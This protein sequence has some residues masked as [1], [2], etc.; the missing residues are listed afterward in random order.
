[1]RNLTP[2]LG[3][4]SLLLLVAPT[5]LVGCPE[6]PTGVLDDDDDATTDDDDFVPG[7]PGAAMLEVSYCLDWSTAN[8]TEPSNITDLLS[9][10]GM[11]LA[12][13]PILVNPTNLDIEN[14]LIWMAGAGTQQGTCLQD[15]SVPTFDLTEPDP[16]SWT[17]PSF[18]VGPSSLS[19]LLPDPVGE[20]LLEDAALT[21]DFTEDGLVIFNSALSGFLN[22]DNV[23]GACLLL[24][25]VT[26]PSGAG[27][28][29]VFAF[30]SAVWD[31]NGQGPL[32]L[33]R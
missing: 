31:D 3:L 32:V 14:S 10:A 2:L 19:I 29:A 17:P 28:C 4:L 21:G 30:D 24:D 1:M 6:P 7:D 15:T 8:I 12:D 23:S 22:V 13:F 27:N 16:G 25:C 11:D 18:S 26:C 20:L 5:F 33:S 9:F